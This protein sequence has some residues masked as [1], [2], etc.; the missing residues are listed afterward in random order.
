[1]DAP[2]AQR[3]IDLYVNTYTLDYGLDGEAAIADLLDRAETAGIIPASDK[4]LFIDR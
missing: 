3:F 2:V 1:M 4:T